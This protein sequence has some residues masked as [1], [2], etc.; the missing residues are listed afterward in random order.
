MSRLR[1]TLAASFR[2]MP[3]FRGKS[4]LG[5]A[6]GRL[7][8]SA[9]TGDNCIV[10]IKMRDGSLMQV[11]VRSR[12]ERRAYWTGEYDREILAR[13][14]ACLQE[15][16]TV[17]DIGANVGFYTMALGRQLKARKGVLHAFEPVKSNFDRLVRCA[18]LNGLEGVVVAHDVAL[19]DEEGVIDLHMESEDNAST[20]N[21][22]MVRE[23]VVGT[24]NMAVNATA[25]ITCLDTYAQEQQIDACHLIKID[26]EGA[27]LLFLRGGATFLGKHRPIIYGEFNP[28]W[29]KQF[30]QSFTDVVNLVTPWDYRFFKQ[31][32]RARFVEM[33]QPEVDIADVLLC[34][35][36]TPA[37]VLT[38]LGV[39]R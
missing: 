12:T 10:T 16:W 9:D 31:A 3:S 15:G 18:A 11:D 2:A 19:G 39:Q 14:S 20:G 21:A 26:V 24:Q 30:G 5:I 34:P 22:V 33:L 29:L 7:V 32:D 13:L 28:Y 8:P 4:R 1:N 35:S 37:S 6:L 38:E 36:E 17:F 25:R 27:E 23:N